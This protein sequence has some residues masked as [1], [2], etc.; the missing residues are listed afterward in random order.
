MSPRR[1]PLDKPGPCL[2]ET[3]QD[4]QQ[5]PL[6]LLALLGSRQSS[7]PALCHQ[8]TREGM[9]SPSGRGPDMGGHAERGGEP[10]WDKKADS[11]AGTQVLPGRGGLMMWDRM[12][13][14][15]AKVQGPMSPLL[16]FLW[17]LQIDHGPHPALQAQ[18][19]PHLQSPQNAHLRSCHPSRPTWAVHRASLSD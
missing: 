12:C 19:R 13:S 5:K 17:K 6:D 11:R 2:P 7:M 16:T 9:A 18:P 1:R 14:R 4:G 8:R 15:T 10:H 3:P